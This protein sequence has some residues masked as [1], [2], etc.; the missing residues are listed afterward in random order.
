MYNYDNATLMKHVL[1]SL[2]NVASRRTT[3]GFTITVI[4]TMLKTLEKEF[5]FLNNINITESIYPEHN[6]LINISIDINLVPPEMIGKSVES[7]IR[8]IC[9]D[10]KEDAGL[11]FIREF[12]ECI[13]E[14][15]LRELNERGVNLNELEDEI[16]RL[17]NLLDKKK[18][19]PI[20][21][22]SEQEK[23]KVSP[24]KSSLLGYTWDSVASW[25][26]E[27]NICILYDKEGKVLD[28]LLLDVIVEDYVRR[29]SEFDEFL[30][31]SDQPLELTDKDYE[32]L[33]MLYTRDMDT[34]LAVVLLHISTDELDEMIRRLLRFEILQYI[35]YNEIKLT[36]RGVNLLLAKK[37]RE[38]Q[39]KKITKSE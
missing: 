31:S 34:D 16:Q 26:Y 21:D 5:T 30:S 12:K 32:F 8:V 2:L 14:D 29:L 10:L 9:M 23:K 17:Y 19:V 20:L 13:G 1:S 27:D 4:R 18:S 37:A 22:A 25:K 38:K 6:E 28:R 7:L 11:F 36:E 35:S 15:I 24:P 33:E 39:E 3:E